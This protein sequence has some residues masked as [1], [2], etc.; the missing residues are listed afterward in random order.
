MNSKEPSALPSLLPAYFSNGQRFHHSESIVD[1]RDRGLAYGD[2]LFETMLAANGSI[3]FWSY[4]HARLL[5]GVNHL[6]LCL[7]AVLLDAHCQSILEYLKSVA[8]P[9]VVKLVVTR[10]VTGRGYIPSAS[11]PQLFATISEMPKNILHQTGCSVHLCQEKLAEPVSWAGLKTLNQLS[12][13]LASAERVHSQFDEGLMV[14][15]SGNVIEAT[16]RNIFCVRDNELFT[17][18]LK[19]CGVAGVMRELII[20]E[21]APTLTIPLNVVQLPLAEL[22]DADEVFLCNSVTGLWPVTR[23][24]ANGKNYIWPVGD[25]TQSIQ[26]LLTELLSKT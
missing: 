23:C 21:L 10:G 6:G 5:R 25:L 20:K 9:C 2:G 15:N 14:S 17:P 13:V 26:K 12:Y 8:Q 3:P 19:G 18:D 16:A 11:T 22:L 1:L 24:E 4:H 7:D